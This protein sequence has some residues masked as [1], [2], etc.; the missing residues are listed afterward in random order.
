MRFPVQYDPV[1]DRP[2]IVWPNGARIAVHF[3]VNVEYFEPGV[4]ATSANPKYVDIKPDVY[5]HSW[6]DYGVRAGIWRLM[7][8]LDRHGVK[9]TVALN[10]L[11]CQH[12]PRIIEEIVKRDWEL[13][14]HG[15]TNSQMLTHLPLEDERKVIRQTLD[16][17]EKSAGVRPRG[18]LGPALAE[19]WHTTTLLEE[20]GIA[21][22]CDW[23][24]DD[25][26]YRMDTPRKKLLS[27]PYSC[28]LNDLHCFLRAGY[29]G[30]KYLQ[31]L[32]D[33][34]DVLYAEGGDRGTVLTVPMHPFVMGHPFRSKYL[35]LALQ[36]M[37][38]KSGVW[39]ATGSQ[40]ADAYLAASAAPD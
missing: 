1:I 12:Y 27:L 5:N 21:Y 10:A 30:P 8:T 34:F 6:R 2:A 11:V 26:P 38:A 16:T 14:G 22:V 18:W 17:I 39:F 4:P 3:V 40:I 24:N 13:M 29:D 35:D 23:I 25:E 9:A 15:L 28:E 19:S 32:K 33:Q 31:L 7:K 36:Y 20:A 37:A